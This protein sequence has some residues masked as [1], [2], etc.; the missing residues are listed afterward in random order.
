[1]GQRASFIGE[2]ETGNVVSIFHI[3]GIE[4]TG[5]KRKNQPKT[6]NGHNNEGEEDNDGKPPGG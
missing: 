5:A 3:M 2:A 1:M 6:G 4:H